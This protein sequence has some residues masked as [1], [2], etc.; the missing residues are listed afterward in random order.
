MA[1]V[2]DMSGEELK[3][4]EDHEQESNSFLLDVGRSSQKPLIRQNRRQSGKSRF[5][6]HYRCWIIEISNIVLN[7]KRVVLQI[8]Q[9]VRFTSYLCIPTGQT[10]YLFA[11]R[12]GRQ[13]FFCFSATCVF[14]KI[15]WCMMVLQCDLWPAWTWRRLQGDIS[16]VTSRGNRIRDLAHP[17]HTFRSFGHAVLFLQRYIFIFYCKVFGNFIWTRVSIY[18]MLSCINR[19]YS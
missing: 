15:D 2:T 19:W 8:S 13:K 10:A 6:K 5:I 4:A 3:W 17:K 1:N 16:L 18:D 9:S 12:L 11:R 7:F 14:T